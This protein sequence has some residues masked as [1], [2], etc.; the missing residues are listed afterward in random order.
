M[1]EQSVPSINCLYH[2]NLSYATTSTPPSTGSYR[3]DTHM[4]D[5]T[6]GSWN[7][8]DFWN[9]HTFVSFF[10]LFSL[11]LSKYNARSFKFFAS[12][13]KRKKISVCIFQ[14]TF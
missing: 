3:R 4:E 13:I 14:Q 1:D 11:F 5:W 12:S 7:G 2:A 6:Q 10:C 9:F 8:P